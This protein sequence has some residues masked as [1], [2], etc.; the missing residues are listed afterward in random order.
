MGVRHI[1][2]ERRHAGG[3]HDE[4]ERAEEHR[5]AARDVA[6]QALGRRDRVRGDG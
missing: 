3:Q 4:L 2:E 6:D 1:V 5:H